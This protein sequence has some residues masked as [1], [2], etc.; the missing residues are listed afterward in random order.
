M[1]GKQFDLAKTTA[2]AILDT[3][4]DDD[5]VNLITFSDN[6]RSVVPCFR[7]KMVNFVHTCYIIL[8][9][10]TI[11]IRSEQLPITSENFEPLPMLSTVKMSPILLVL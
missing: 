10:T 1:S 9:F 6:V 7:E 3:L 8:L 11:L 2:F 5:Y 4:G